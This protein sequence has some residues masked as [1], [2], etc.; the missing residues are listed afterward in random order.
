MDTFSALREAISELPVI[1]THTHYTS[2]TETY[3]DVFP[4]VLGYIK[5]D[6]RIAAGSEATG[7]VRLLADTEKP[8]EQRAR[9]FEQVYAKCRFSSYTR[10]MLRGLRA[11]WGVE[12]VSYRSLCALNERLGERNNEMLA[13]ILQEHHVVAQ[14][15]DIFESRFFAIMEGKDNDYSPVS[16]FAFPLPA[17]HRLY[18]EADLRGLES[19]LGVL[20]ASLDGYVQKVDALLEKAALWGAVCVKDQSAYFR[21]LDYQ[22]PTRCEAE[23]AYNRLLSRPLVGLGD[24]EGKPL[25]DWLFQHFVEKAGELQLPVQL[26][27]GL[28]DRVVMYDDRNGGDCRMADAALLIPT[29]ER[30]RNV[31][32]DLFHG[33][34]P[35]LDTIL[36]LGKNFPNVWVDLCW[37][38]TIDPLYAIEAM[39]RAVLCLPTSKLFAFGGDAFAMEN[40]IGYLEQALD[41]IAKALS[42]LVDGAWINPEEALEIARIWL[43]DGP[44]DFFHITFPQEKGA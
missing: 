37:V 41:N 7:L 29:L 38:Q 6:L 15:A 24:A 34:W 9:L 12:N 39:K 36:F 19:I 42:E 18:N 8:F 22:H 31:N 20:P 25:D 11:C 14:V 30:Q 21:S 13:R 43:Y 4:I 35:Y 5:S 33:N 44:R 1:E 10:A 26:H 28:Q 27:T 2:N 40:G 23:K 3:D 17:F 32:F 16:R